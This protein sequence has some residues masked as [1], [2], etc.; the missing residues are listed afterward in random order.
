MR[1]WS[2]DQGGSRPP[3][4]ELSRGV[5][6]VLRSSRSFLSS[7]A[8]RFAPPPFSRGTSPPFAQPPDRS[9]PKRWTLVAS[10]FLRLA[11]L[12]LKVLH[13]FLRIKGLPL[14][15]G[16]VFVFPFKGEGSSASPRSS[17]APSRWPSG[18]APSG[19]RALP[20]NP[21]WGLRLHHLLSEVARSETPLWL[22]SLLLGQSHFGFFSVTHVPTDDTNCCWLQCPKH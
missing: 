14:F 13:L 7:C 3:L 18:L 11:D 9:P 12:G 21:G 4:L 16:G 2:R 5:L 20:R 8:F 10:P 1:S 17:C 19:T 15:R 6:L 22:P